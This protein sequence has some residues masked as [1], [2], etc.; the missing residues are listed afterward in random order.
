MATWPFFGG[1]RNQP[2]LAG[3]RGLLDCFD[4][5]VYNTSMSLSVMKDMCCW[6]CFSLGCLGS[7]RVG[8]FGIGVWVGA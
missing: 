6:G 2:E 7:S 1:C 5:S 8:L 3:E 4:S